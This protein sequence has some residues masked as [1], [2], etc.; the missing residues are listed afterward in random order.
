MKIGSTIHRLTSCPSTNEFALAL[1]REGAEEGTVVIAAEQTAGR[2][3]KGRVWHSP[4]GK[5]LYA[6]VILRPRRRDLSLLPLVAGIAG[7]EAVRDAAGVEARLKWPNDIVCGGRKLGGI[8]CE[9]SYSG[10]FPVY[11]VLG[12]GL[13]VG[14]KRDDF[15]PEL[16]MQ[17]TSLRLIGRKDIDMAKLESCLW[18]RLDV[19]YANFRQGKKVAVVRAFK[20]WLSFPIGIPIRVATE[21][22]FLAGVFS[23]IDLQARLVLATEEGERR[24]TSPEILGIDM[25]PAVRRKQREA[26]NASGS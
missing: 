7:A 26:K 24:L 3:T 23:G 10:G 18:E 2:G 19:W 16:R 12:I 11:A 22:G 1:A 8:L 25:A 13:N 15:P 17:A 14:Q 20:S 4:A 5:G 6:S 21:G 9:G